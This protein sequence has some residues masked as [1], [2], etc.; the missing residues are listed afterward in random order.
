MGHTKPEVT[1]MPEYKAPL[2]DIEFVKVLS[3]LSP[4]SPEELATFDLARVDVIVWA[5][6]DF[7]ELD[8]LG[9]QAMR[10]FV[11]R[12]GGLIAYLG[13]YA[14]PAGRV[15]GFTPGGEKVWD[16]PVQ[17][18]SGNWHWQYHT[19]YQTPQSPGSVYNGDVVS[20]SG[21]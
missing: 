15:N 13:D 6:A 2:R 14:R 5:D 12:G 21:I 10:T 20:K 4:I 7:H 9:A 19:G 17:D 1:I 3:F 18:A 11:A 8:E 16:V